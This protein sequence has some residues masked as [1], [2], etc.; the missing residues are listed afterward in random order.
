MAQ[1]LQKKSWLDIEVCGEDEISTLRKEVAATEAE[2]EQ[3]RK[4]LA[5]QPANWLYPTGRFAHV[6]TKL[7]AVGI[8][9]PAARRR[10]SPTRSTPQPA[11]PERRSPSRPAKKTRSRNKIVGGTESKAWD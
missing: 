4:Q 6:F 8:F 5:R 10:R 1:Y 11:E 3:L 7:H 2:A 9:R